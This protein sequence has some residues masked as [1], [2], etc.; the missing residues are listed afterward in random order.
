VGNDAWDWR[1]GRGLLVDGP[2]SPLELDQRLDL[3]ELL[4]SVVPHEQRG[5]VATRREVRD[6]WENG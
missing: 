5:D 1:C 4:W 6:S 3:G 2:L